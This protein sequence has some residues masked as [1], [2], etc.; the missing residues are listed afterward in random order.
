MLVKGL[1]FT[2]LV[3]SAPIALVT[4]QD[5]R[6]NSTGAAA[7]AEA[8][9]AA[10]AA[11]LQRLEAQNK[12]AAADLAAARRE[13]AAARQDLEK[14]GHQLDQALDALESTFEPQR[15]RNCS[16]SRS[17]ALMSHYEWLRT[18]GLDQRALA[19]LNKVVDQ[20]G[21]NV[22]RC[23]SVAWDLMT[24]KETAGKF[25]DVALAI[26]ERMQ[27]SPGELAHNQLDTVAFA[28]FLNGRVDEAIVLEK[29]AIE[30]G[31]NSDDYRR[32][33]RTYESAR[34]ALA[35]AAA[36]APLPAGTMV[37]SRDD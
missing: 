2:A 7:G 24:D 12:K 25:D 11:D 22:Q 1:V 13:L 10:V 21:D 5:P 4:K 16:P 31:G 17:R 8:A 33:L 30:R 18:N 34:D 27:K 35:K 32:R 6:P 3:A 37:A 14:L 29:Q 9:A 19:T 23:N 36:A 26:A 20:L 28:H 15:D